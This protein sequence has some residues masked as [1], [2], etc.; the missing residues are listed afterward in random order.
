MYIDSMIGIEMQYERGQPSTWLDIFGNVISEEKMDEITSKYYLPPEKDQ[1]LLGNYWWVVRIRPLGG[2]SKK[3]EYMV[4]KDYSYRRVAWDFAQ[5]KTLTLYANRWYHEGPIEK[6]LSSCLYPYHQYCPGLD[7]DFRRCNINLQLNRLQYMEETKEPPKNP[8][9]LQTIGR[10]EEK[11][12]EPHEAVQLLVDTGA[13]PSSTRQSLEDYLLE[14][15]PSY[16]ATEASLKRNPFATARRFLLMHQT[17]LGALLKAIKYVLSPIVQHGKFVN[18]LPDP[19][20]NEPM[21]DDDEGTTDEDDGDQSPLHGDSSSSPKPTIEESTI[22]Y[23]QL[24]LP[25]N[26]GRSE[27]NQDRQS[28]GRG[29]NHR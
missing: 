7:I 22:Q 1:A 16:D 15:Q 26:Q 18:N 27:L 19:N 9:C 24:P 21:D 4:N 25:K 28:G 5:L 17:R 20:L 8:Q 6:T 2:S 13:I 14:L 29:G 23:T 11:K 3:Y 12:R 10:K